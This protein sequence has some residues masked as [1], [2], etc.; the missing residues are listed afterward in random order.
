MQGPVYVVLRHDLVCAQQQE[1]EQGARHRAPEHRMVAEMID[2]ERPEDPVLD[3][4]PH[5]PVVA[6]APVSEAVTICSQPV[7]E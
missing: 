1:R 2:L 6:L 5:G 3:P 7:L 4:V